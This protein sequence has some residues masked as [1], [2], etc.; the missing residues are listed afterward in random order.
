MCHDGKTVT[1]TKPCGHCVCVCLYNKNN[2]PNSNTNYQQRKGRRWLRAKAIRNTQWVW[3]VS[4]KADAEEDRYARCEN[5]AHQGTCWGH[6]WDRMPLSLKNKMEKPKA[7]QDVVTAGPVASQIWAAQTTCHS[8]SP[9]SG[10]PPRWALSFALGTLF[11]CW[12]FF[13]LL[14]SCA[15]KAR[16]WVATM[17]HCCNTNT[18]SPV[19]KAPC[20]VLM[21]HTSCTSFRTSI[22]HSFPCNR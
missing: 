19:F 17:P 21:A 2:S 3:E 22:Y 16:T 4:L 14:S 8:H 5:L 9:C 7:E 13:V 15:Q 18:A 11:L 10:T 6:T 1:T 12:P 20:Q